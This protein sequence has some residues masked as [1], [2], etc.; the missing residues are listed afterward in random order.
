[1]AAFRG[2]RMQIAKDRFVVIEYSLR[3]D[4]GS[5]VKG[6]KSPASMNF[7]AGYGQVLPALE[8]RLI[9]LGQ[10]AQTELEIPAAE[11]FGEH[12]ESLIRTMD[13]SS[14]P[15]G[16][17]LEPG[18]WALARNK[19]TGAQYSY[20]VVGK[21]DSTITVDYNHPMAGKD[22]HYHVKVALVRPALEEE[23]EFLRPCEHGREASPGD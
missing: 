6:E 23:L 17:D 15:A 10:G 18:R 7:I 3:L 11:A 21:T 14:F 1:V 16:R 9:G 13:L 4:D 8:K 22:L 12:D 19:A 20:L 5:F 2:K